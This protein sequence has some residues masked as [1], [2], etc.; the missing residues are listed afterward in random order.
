MLYSSILTADAR[1]RYGH[2]SVDRYL[3]VYD[4]RTLRAFPPLQVCEDLRAM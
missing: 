3:M 1:F 4:L 2:M